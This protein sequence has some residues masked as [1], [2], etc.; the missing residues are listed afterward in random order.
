MKDEMNPLPANG[1]ALSKIQ[2]V[3]FGILFWGLF[4]LFNMNFQL[5][6]LP[7]QQCAF[8][9]EEI[10]PTAD[11]ES[12]NYITPVSSTV[13]FT[14]LSTNATSYHWDFGDGN[15][16]TA[17]NPQ[18]VYQETGTYQVRLTAYADGCESVSI[19]IEE[20]VNH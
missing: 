1:I 11:F 2:Q 7:Y 8:E 14:N 12:S 5:V 16:S 19:I 15:S 13:T 9:M 20:V 10:C 17:T 18:H 3:T 6:K 4:G